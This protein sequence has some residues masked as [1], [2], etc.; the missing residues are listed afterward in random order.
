VTMMSSTMSRQR[1]GGDADFIPTSAC[2]ICLEHLSNR[3]LKYHGPIYLLLPQHPGRHAPLV[4][5]VR[6]L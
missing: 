2:D 1:G 4:L 5:Y 3:I 6:G